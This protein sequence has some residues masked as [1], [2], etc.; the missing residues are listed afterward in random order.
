MYTTSSFDF[1]CCLRIVKGG[2]GKAFALIAFPTETPPLNSYKYIVA[3]SFGV[4][5]ELVKI[6]RLSVENS[7]TISVALSNNPSAV[8]QSQSLA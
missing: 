7:H 5:W 2:V 1:F 4:A 3:D 6:K 8:L